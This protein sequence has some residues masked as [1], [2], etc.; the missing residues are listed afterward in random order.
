MEALSLFVHGV[1]IA[2]KRS[3]FPGGEE[4]VRVDD[5]YTPVSSEAKI[6]ANLRSSAD[7]MALLLLTD[8]L[9]RRVPKI[10]IDLHMP[11]LPYARQDRVCAPG[12]ALSLRVFCDLINAQGYESVTVWDVHSDTAL[13]L[14]HRCTNAWSYPAIQRI[15]GNHPSPVMLVAPDAGALKKV[16]YYARLLGIPFIRADKSRDPADGSITGTVVYSEHVGDAD[17]LI[18]DDI[19]DGGRTFIELAKVL[20]PL[21]SCRVMLYVTHGI[22]SNGTAPLSSY[23]DLVYVA[24]SFVDDLP[25]N[26]KKVSL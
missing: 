6:V 23:F 3:R 7:V 16:S 12:E 1:P 17:L 24:N 26:F 11:Y 2:V 21:T 18:V 8:G 4:H 22:F 25:A 5:F 9:R 20:R 15:V 10:K 14:L 19:C 13:A